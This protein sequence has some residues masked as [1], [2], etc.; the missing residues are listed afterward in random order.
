MVGVGV[1]LLFGEARLRLVEASMA[2]ALMRVAH[3]ADAHALGSSVFFL[4]SQQWIGFTVATGCTAALLIA[5]FFFI[6]A[7]LMFLRRLKV[8][9]TLLALAVVSLLIWLVNQLRLILIGA[10]MQLWGFKT[11]YDRSHVLAGGVLSTVGVTI[12]IVAFLMFMLRERE[13]SGSSGHQAGDA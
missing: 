5:P 12:G 1:A 13:A 7:A 3:L 10:S 8:S 11:G 2:A 9:H 6:G 4:H